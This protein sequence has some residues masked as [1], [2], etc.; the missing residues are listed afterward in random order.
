MSE[1]KKDRTH[2]PAKP[3]AYDV[4]Y[5]KPPKATRFKRGKS[6]NPKG[7]PKG[8]R[9][10]LPGKER[11]AAIVLDEASRN[12]TLNEGG[13]RTTVT[14]ARAITRRI[15]I[16]AAQGNPRAQ[17]QFTDLVKE[18]ERL[19]SLQEGNFLETVMAYK[20]TWTAEL[21]T[22][23]AQ[24]LTGPAPLPHPD[25]LIVDFQSGEVMVVGPMT[26]DQKTMPNVPAANPAPSKEKPWLIYG[27]RLEVMLLKNLPKPEW[28][29]PA[30][31]NTE[32]SKRA[33]EAYCA[34]LDEVA[35][36]KAMSGSGDLL[37]CAEERVEKIEGVLK[38]N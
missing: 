1:G 15:T 17:R 24:G 5:C 36:I 31:K 37:Q 35:K 27:S 11:L 8:A 9:N 7:R 18:A 14:M 32:L 28:R 30:P 29:M 22:R 12:I 23:A 3:D 16:S 4:G 21:A 6:G 38:L 26:P 33:F 10:K 20:I 19:V 2:P 34:V 25:D 13:K